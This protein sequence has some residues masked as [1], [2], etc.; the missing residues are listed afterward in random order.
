V[1]LHGGPG[2]Y[3]DDLVP[4]FCRFAETHRVIFYDQRG[5]GSSRMETL[6]ESNFNVDLLV[7]D[8]EGLRVVF[9]LEELNQVGHSWGG[10][11]AMYYAVEHPDRFGR[12]IWIDAAPVNAELVIA[13]YES[14]IGRYA[15]G[16]WE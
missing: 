3:H 1:V 10:L 9:G 14:Q 16:D 15:P 7:S 12:L 5:N 13:S 6:D 11:L 2:I 8:L 4:F